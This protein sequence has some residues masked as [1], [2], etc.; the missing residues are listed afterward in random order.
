MP[1]HHHLHIEHGLAGPRHVADAPAPAA[2]RHSL[3]AA[4]GA[5]FLIAVLRATR[6]EYL[7]LFLLLFLLFLWR[8]CTAV[9]QQG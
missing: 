3:A 2:A 9:A 5:I 6:A 8:G 4:I 1:A 7:L